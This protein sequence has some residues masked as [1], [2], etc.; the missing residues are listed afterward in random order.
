MGVWECRGDVGVPWVCGSAIGVPW[1]FGSTMCKDVVSVSNVSVSR[2]VLER[3]DLVSFRD[4]DVSIGLV[5][6][7]RLERLKTYSVSRDILNVSRDVS[8]KH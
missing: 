8:A 5:S 4:I 2:R 1:G 6:V 3:L 7:L